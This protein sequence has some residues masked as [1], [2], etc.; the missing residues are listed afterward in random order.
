MRQPDNRI[1]RRDGAE[2]FFATL[3]KRRKGAG[4]DRVEKKDLEEFVDNQR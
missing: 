2:A 1:S 3:V 4:T